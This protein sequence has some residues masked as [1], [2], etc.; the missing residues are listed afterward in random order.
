MSTYLGVNDPIVTSAV[1]EIDF[2]CV[3]IKGGQGELLTNLS[4]AIIDMKNHFV[5]LFH[6]F[7]LL[8]TLERM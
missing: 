4:I 6:R 7:N 2:K 1:L 3:V 8:T 5:K